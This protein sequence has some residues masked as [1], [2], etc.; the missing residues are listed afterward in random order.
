MKERKEIWKTNPN[1]ET[2]Q[3]GGGWKGI[4]TCAIWSTW[5]DLHAWGDIYTS[6][7]WARTREWSVTYCS[8]ILQDFGYGIAGKSYRPQGQ[9]LKM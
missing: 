3:G 7:Y 2:Y 9:S 8:D 1:K 5:L 6:A 4:V